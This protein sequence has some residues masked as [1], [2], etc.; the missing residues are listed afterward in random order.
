MRLIL[1]I[2][3]LQDFIGSLEC[4]VGELVGAPGGKLEKPLRYVTVYI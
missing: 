4:S 2:G 3:T 1:V